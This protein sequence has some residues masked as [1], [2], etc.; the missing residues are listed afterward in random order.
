MAVSIR[1]LC[2]SEDETE[3]EKRAETII[4]QIGKQYDDVNREGSNREKKKESNTGRNKSKLC[5]Q[6]IK[7]MLK[8][9][10]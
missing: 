9:S 3:A 4:G 1:S 2:V 8:Q 5:H 6:L 7:Q 10:F